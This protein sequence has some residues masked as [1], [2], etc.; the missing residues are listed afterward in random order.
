MIMKEGVGGPGVLRPDADTHAEQR[1]A[2]APTDQRF[3]KG[4]QGDR[5]QRGEPDGSVPLG[6]ASLF[7]PNFRSSCIG[8]NLRF[9]IL[10][11]LENALLRADWRLGR[12]G[13]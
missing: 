8:T 12:F 6:A 7:I 11:G 13:L 10:L 1:P 2:D 4:P 9:M 5:R 3:F